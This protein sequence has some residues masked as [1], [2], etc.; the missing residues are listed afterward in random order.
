MTSLIFTHLSPDKSSNV[1]DEVCSLWVL[2]PLLP[3]RLK[4]LHS[5]L[6]ELGLRSFDLQEPQDRND[7]VDLEIGDRIT[8]TYKFRNQPEDWV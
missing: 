5:G 7:A 3:M 1:L 8:L 6:V 2:F 4:P